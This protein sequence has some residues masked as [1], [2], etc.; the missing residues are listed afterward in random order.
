MTMGYHSKN[1]KSYLA[2]S[3]H[4][5]MDPINYGLFRKYLID[6][7]IQSDYIHEII[8]ITFEQKVHRLPIDDFR[9]TK[10]DFQNMN[11]RWVPLKYHTGRFITFYKLLDFLILLQF[12]LR[13]FLFKKVD[14]LIGFT[15]LSAVL[16]YLISR[17][18]NKKYVLLNVEP[19]SEYMADFGFWQK[20]GLKYQLLKRLEQLSV[21][22]AQKVG[23]PTKAY[24][25]EVNRLNLKGRS[26]YLPTGI[27]LTHGISGTMNFDFSK[28]RQKYGWKDDDIIFLYLGK[29]GGIYYDHKDYYKFFERLLP[30]NPAYRGWIITGEIDDELRE[31]F[32]DTNNK[33]ILTG[34]VSYDHLHEILSIVNFGIL[35][36]PDFPSQRFRCPIKTAD[37]WSVGV[38]IIISHGVSDDYVLARKYKI[39]IV[40]RNLTP[41]PAEELE[42]LLA[43]LDVKNRCLEIAAKFRGH[44]LTVNFLRNSLLD[45]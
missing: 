25:R 26:V 3:Y 34:G 37:Y 22:N 16:V 35:L 41:P 20:K 29:F 31:C 40:V 14:Y 21:Q 2:I 9:R 44:Q 39:G 43:D 24:L 12:V 15:S 4:S 45:E 19:H 18:L 13:V 27:D 1:K 23:I 33:V 11:I 38:P 5:L 32:S 6:F 7:Q 8:Y 42:S 17:V 36:V 30:M 28:I 10:T